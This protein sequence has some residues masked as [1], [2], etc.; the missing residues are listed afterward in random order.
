MLTPRENYIRNATFQGPEYI[1]ASVHIS[2]ASL[3]EG[4]PAMEEVMVRHPVLFPNFEPG[5]IDFEHYEFLPEETIGDVVDPW[6]CR[7]RCSVNGII[8][9]VVEHPLA[10]WS[11]LENLTVPPVLPQNAQRITGDWDDRRTRI[12]HNRREGNLTE[13]AIYHGFFFMRL[14]YLRGFENLMCDLIEEPPELWRLIEMIKDHDAA[15]VRRYLDLDVDVMYFGEDLGTQTSS[16]ISPEMFAKFVTPVYKELMAPV[17]EAGK[18]VYLHSDGCIIDLMGDFAAAGVDII[19]PQ[20]L[21]NGIDAL[22]EEV[23]GRFC[24]SLDV[25]RQSIVPFGTRG[26]IHALIEEEVRKL[27]DPSGGLQ[28]VAGIYPP[29]PPENVD[30]LCEALEKFR[31]FWW[32]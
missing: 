15:L 32:E 27:G 23:K 13:G 14:H 8:G 19:N 2:P 21:V 11:D 18:L 17:K 16:F 31:T 3:I 30:A 10:D 1:P 6:G 12:E 24:I 22:A 25:D 9:T 7:W 29:T 20:D 5:K 4:G 28:L 26:E